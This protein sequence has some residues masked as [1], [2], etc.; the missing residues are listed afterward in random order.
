MAIQSHTVL[1]NDQTMKPGISLT[2][3]AP[4]RM[5]F[6]ILRNSLMLLFPFTFSIQKDF[7]KQIV[8][9]FNFRDVF[10]L[11]KRANHPISKVRCS[12]IS[13]VIA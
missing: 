6:K 13:D 11:H 8:I 1:R 5:S 4:D 12:W 7:V 10:L 9:L 3:N 2:G